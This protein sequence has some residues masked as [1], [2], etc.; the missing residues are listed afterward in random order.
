MF[1]DKYHLEFPNALYQQFAK[2]FVRRPDKD[3]R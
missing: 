3:T 2:T 1:T